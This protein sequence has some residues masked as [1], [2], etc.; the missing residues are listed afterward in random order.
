MT[1]YNSVCVCVYTGLPHLS[2]LL[3]HTL[4]PH[5]HTH[6]PPTHPH[7]HT[8]NRC[9]SEGPI[10][11]LR[12][13]ACTQQ[14]SVLSQ[15]LQDTSS[16]FLSRCLLSRRDWEH[17]HQPPERRR[18]LCGTGANAK[19]GEHVASVASQLEVAQ[20]LNLLTECF[21][22]ATVCDKQHQC[23]WLSTAKNTHRAA[24]G[25]VCNSNRSS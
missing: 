25:R 7:T 13:P 6:P 23:S 12:L 4:L 11:S 24:R 3:P 2:L 14:W 21:I 22:R 9:Y 8:P 17:F 18:G 20:P 5:T 19:V 10:F 1:E 15:E 16:C